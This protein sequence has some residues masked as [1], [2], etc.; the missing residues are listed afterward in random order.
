MPAQKLRW[1][2]TSAAGGLT[3]TSTTGT[4]G[5]A[6]QGRGATG[7]GHRR[8]GA[9]SILSGDRGGPPLPA[10]RERAFPRRS[11]WRPSG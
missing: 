10:A 1:P 6:P 11:G 5:A 3:R 4:A 7:R 9:G 8:L 2:A